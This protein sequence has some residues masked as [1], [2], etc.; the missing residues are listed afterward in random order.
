MAGQLNA[1]A[2]EREYTYPMDQRAATLWYHDHRMGFTGAS[3]W[4]GLA[5]LHLVRDDEE[6][7]LPL[8]SGDRDV[9]LM[10]TDRSFGADGGFH[11]PSV[12]PALRT[13]GVTPPYMN[14]VLGDV[15]L[16]NGAPWPVLAADRARYRF[17]LLNASNARRY[18][19]ALDPPPP[20]GQG[21]VQVGSD[22]GLLA[23]PVPHDVIDLAPAER[24]DVVVDLARY[25]PGTRV[26]LV[27]RLATGPAGEVLRLDVGTARTADPSAVPARLSRIDRLDPHRATV[28]REFRFQA[29]GPQWTINGRPYRPGHPRAVSRL[30]DVEIWRFVTDLHHPVHLH[31]NQFQVLSRNGRAPGPYDAGWKDTVDLRPAEAVEVAVRFTGY[32]GR[33][34]LHC[35]NLEHEDMAMMAEFRTD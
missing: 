22:G 32:R 3:V 11:Y 13:P 16:V 31:L 18:R 9:P 30:G 26:R 5:G 35:H 14:G 8:P 12:D 29:N 28:T 33:Y 27:N 24:F 34:L 15:I 1:V 2:G 19:L 23:R 25:R 6:E 17:R 10:I 21:F 20:G 7:A 4:R